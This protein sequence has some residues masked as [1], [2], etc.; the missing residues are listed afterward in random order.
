MNVQIFHQNLSANYITDS[1]HVKEL[2]D[3]Q[4]PA[5]TSSTIV[6]HIFCFS[7]NTH[8]EP[9]HDHFWNV[10]HSKMCSTEIMFAKS[11]TKHLEAISSQ[12][13]ELHANIWNKC[14]VKIAELFQYITKP[15]VIIKHKWIEWSQLAD[16]LRKLGINMH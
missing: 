10:C 5:W 12:F 2:T 13:T 9:T 11:P 8:L 6:P 7:G 4:Q 15:H 1:N 3:W 16:W 14:I